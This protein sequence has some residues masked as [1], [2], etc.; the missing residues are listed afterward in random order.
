M[1]FIWLY[2]H[3]KIKPVTFSQRTGINKTPFFEITKNCFLRKITWCH[4]GDPNSLF[5]KDYEN[6][7][8]Y[9]VMWP[10]LLFNKYYENAK[11]YIVMWPKLLVL[12]KQR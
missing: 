8:E 7:D 10:K 5:N 2:F 3:A 6:A 12:L 11:E 1:N 4:A 9:I